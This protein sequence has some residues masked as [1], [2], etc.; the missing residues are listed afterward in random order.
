MQARRMSPYIIQLRRRIFWSVY[1]LDRMCVL[2]PLFHL[3]C[4]QLT[5]LV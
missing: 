2:L 5:V 4:L 1:T 3:A